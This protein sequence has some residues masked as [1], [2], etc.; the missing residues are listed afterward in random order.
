M[1][2]GLEIRRGRRH[3]GLRRRAGA[4]NQN[5]FDVPYPVHVL[6]LDFCTIEA[7]VGFYDNG[8]D[9]FDWCDYDITSIDRWDPVEMWTRYE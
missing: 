2:G 7:E 8:P 6:L 9:P 5:C 4:G 1:S 3:G